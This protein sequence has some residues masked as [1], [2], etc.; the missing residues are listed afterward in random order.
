[1]RLPPL[2]ADEWDD[3]TRAALAG[4]MPRARQ[5]PDDAGT[6]LATLVR[7]PALTKAFLGLSVHLLFRSTLP[8]RLR[9]LAILRVAYRRDC[10]YESAHHVE[11][12]AEVGLDAGEV[13]AAQ[14]GESADDFERAVL[15]AV[16]ELD[17]KSAITDSTWATLEARLD[18]RQLMDLIFTIGTYN[19][20]AVAYNTFGVKPEQKG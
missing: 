4:M 20:M 1:M 19:T 9:E 3:E 14:R 16:D 7:H 6:A 2:P 10:E 12:A 17:E 13:A 5:N 8:P 11:M 18:E 15:R